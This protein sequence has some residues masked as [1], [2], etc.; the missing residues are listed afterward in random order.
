[1]GESEFKKSIFIL[2]LSFYI[3]TFVILH[4]QYES[5]MI[6]CSALGAL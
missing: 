3:L 4:N 2:V 6:N 5:H 1:M